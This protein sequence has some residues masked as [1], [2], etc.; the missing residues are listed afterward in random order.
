MT[1]WMMMISTVAAGM[2]ASVVAQPVVYFDADQIPDPAHI[3]RL[4]ADGPTDSEAPRVRTRAIRLLD[5][6]SSRPTGNADPQPLPGR[7]QPGFVSPPMVA[8]A[9]GART[10]EPRSTEPRTSGGFALPIQFNFDSTQMIGKA[11]A[12]LDAVAEGIKRLAAHAIVHI[13]GHTDAYG[14]AIYNTELSLKRAMAVRS[15]FVRKHG[16]PGAMLVAVGKGTSAP[17]NGANPYAP[18][19]R[20]VEFRA[21]YE[22]ADAGPTPDKPAKRPHSG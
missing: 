22:V 15:Y 7:F 18:E 9:S 4:L 10:P 8:T 17:R 16:I 1:R 12:Q 20:R 14:V 19:N 13:E 3:A 21:E 5:A 2:A 6:G 11:D